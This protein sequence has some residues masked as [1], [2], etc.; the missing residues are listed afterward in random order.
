MSHPFLRLPDVSRAFCLALA[1]NHLGELLFQFGNYGGGTG[2]AINPR[3]L[4]VDSFGHILVADMMH[5]AV[6]IYNYPFIITQS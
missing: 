3:G 2:R 1:Y 6:S 4:S 5:N